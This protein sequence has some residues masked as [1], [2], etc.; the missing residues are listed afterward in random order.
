M[1]LS[2]TLRFEVFKRDKFTCQYCGKKAPDV[3]LHAD[4]IHPKAEGGTDDPLNLTTACVDCN[5]GKGK[6]MLSD[7]SVVT[8]QRAQLEELQERQEQIQ[9]LIDW[10]KSLGGLEDSTTAAIEKY[11][12]ELSGWNLNET[13]LSNLKKWVKQYGIGEVMSAMRAAKDSYFEYGADGKVTQAS[14][15]VGFKKVG[16][17]CHVAR[18]E[19]EKPYIKDLFYIRGIMRNRFNVYR[20]W[21]ALQRL[22][23]AH[24]AGASIETLKRIA[25]LAS[26]W[27]RWGDLM[28]DLEKSL[29]QDEGT[30]AEG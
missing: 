6:R 5:Q 11:W 9:M 27:S 14:I 8:K 26:S 18:A 13:G 16:G 29:T 12:T 3:V 4:H 15:E 19:R 1:A 24:M 17:I 23:D 2:K 28:A 7:D 21:E 10:Q 30:D 25:F 22:E 20:P